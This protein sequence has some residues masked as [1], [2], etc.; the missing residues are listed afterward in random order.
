MQEYLE[1]GKV[2]GTHG[3]R[4][5]LRVDPWYSKIFMSI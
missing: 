5:E 4:G 3:L 1:I 2:V